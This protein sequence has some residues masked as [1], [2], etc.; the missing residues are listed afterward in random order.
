M[1]QLEVTL[2]II[3][4]IFV[5]QMMINFYCFCKIRKVKENFMSNAILTCTMI[6]IIMRVVEVSFGLYYKSINEDPSQC[7]QDANGR[8]CVI[9]EFFTLIFPFYWFNCA[10]FI[11]LV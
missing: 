4:G 2:V 7:D 9:V 11:I 8:L 3:L 1:D 10:G 6:A 5:V